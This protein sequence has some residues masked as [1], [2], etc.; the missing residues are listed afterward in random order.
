MWCAGNHQNAVKWL[1]DA[2]DMFQHLSADD[3]SAHSAKA[4]W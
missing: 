4:L 1:E 3:A 2:L